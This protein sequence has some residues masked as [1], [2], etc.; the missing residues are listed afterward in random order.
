MSEAS[1]AS[2]VEA[3]GESLAAAGIALFVAGRRGELQFVNAALAEALHAIPARTLDDIFAGGWGTRGAPGRPGWP[4]PGVE[5]LVRLNG[6]PPR[7][8]SLVTAPWPGDRR[9][10]ILVECT[11]RVRKDA[12]RLER[13]L[14]LTRAAEDSADAFVSLDNDGTIRQWNDG[15]RLMFGYLA[16][17]ALGKPYDALLVPQDVRERG[18]IARIDHLMARDG[19]VRGYETVR[20]AKG[21]KPIPVELTVT[22]LA[23][24]SGRAAGRSVIYRD[25]SERMRLEAALRKTVDELKEANG[26][27]RRNQERLIALEKLSAIGEMSARVAHEIRT[28]LV[29]IGGFANTLMRET[30]PESPQRQYLEIIR[31]EVR[32]LE[33]IVSEILEY[34]RPPRTDYEPCDLNDV[35]RQSLRPFEGGLGEKHVA[36]VLRLMDD[37][38][39]IKASRYQIHQVFTNLIQNAVQAMP[40]GGTLTLTT[41]GG[42][43]HVSVRVSDTGCGIPASDHRRIFKPFYTT[44]PS[45]SGLGLAITSQI[46]VQHNGTIGFE[47]A[48]GKGTTFD[49]RLPLDRETAE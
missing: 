40:E 34:V 21:G 19:F 3:I 27:I 2:E 36:L 15:A 39:A 45:G 32:R 22:P 28:P 26:N 30:P 48:E 10:G 44:K 43:N 14:Y 20:M 8:F 11:E 35:V 42:T 29:T 25:I 17:E 5:R 7:F 9:L 1:R 18:D 16:A 41:T 24:E 46:V 47:S 23:D 4:R 49:V 6:E 12:A 37:L 38:P 13:D 31:E 33:A